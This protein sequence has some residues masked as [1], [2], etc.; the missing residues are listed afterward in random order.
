MPAM[1]WEKAGNRKLD[2]SKGSY[3]GAHEG[4]FDGG[5][6]ERRIEEGNLF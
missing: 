5:A 2:I 3:R 6:R 4:E 1:M